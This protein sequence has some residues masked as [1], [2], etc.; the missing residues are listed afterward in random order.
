VLF[1]ASPHAGVGRVHGVESDARAPTKRA[2]AS[3]KGKNKK[4]WL[5]LCART[6]TSVSMGACM[7]TSGPRSAWR[8][9][10]VIQISA[11]G[12]PLP[13]ESQDVVSNPGCD[14]CRTKALDCKPGVVI[15]LEFERATNPVSYSTPH[16]D[17]DGSLLGHFGLSYTAFDP[18]IPI[19]AGV[20]WSYSIANV[21]SWTFVA[22]SFYANSEIAKSGKDTTLYAHRETLPR[23]EGVDA[24]VVA[25]KLRLNDDGV[26]Q[27]MAGTA[28]E[29]M[30]WPCELKPGPYHVVIGQTKWHK[31]RAYRVEQAQDA[32][33][34]LRL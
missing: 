33:L 17:V 23:L 28:E 19:Q 12:L 10:K 34:R 29:W 21:T 27:V 2:P 14:V 25:V 11:D 4:S 20:K 26:P 9:H 31:L 13:P 32:D 18:T 16:G 5:H 7:S 6:S 8:T 3:H 24:P 1:E 30:N 22:G 15:T